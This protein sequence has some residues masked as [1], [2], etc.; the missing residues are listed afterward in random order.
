[1]LFANIMQLYANWM[2]LWNADLSESL[3]MKILVLSGSFKRGRVELR[4]VLEM[5]SEAGIEAVSVGEIVRIGKVTSEGGLSSRLSTM[6]AGGIVG[7]IAAG[8]LAGG[9]TGPAGAVVGAVAGA[10]L[11][12][13]KI[14]ICRVDLR[15]GR[16]FI[17]SGS[18][19][20]WDTLR[21]MSG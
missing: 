17:A 9:L 14:V 5:K 16:H 7:G 1:L 11:G 15:D 12:S 8:V 19:A 4:D 2:H 13:G 6:A 18:P 10:A 20:A 3:L 21:A